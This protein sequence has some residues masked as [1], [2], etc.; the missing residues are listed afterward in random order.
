[1][2]A[3]MHRARFVRAERWLG[4]RRKP[5]ME[6]KAVQYSRSRDFEGSYEVED[7]TS[8]RQYLPSAPICNFKKPTK[9]VPILFD[10]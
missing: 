1:M 2:C 3:C 6:G 4:V 7:F 8:S 9:V 10:H 5:E